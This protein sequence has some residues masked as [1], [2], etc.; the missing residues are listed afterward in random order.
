MN[1]TYK[2]GLFALI[3]FSLLFA[4]KPAHNNQVNANSNTGITIPILQDG[5]PTPEVEDQSVIGST[6]GILMMGII[7]TAIAII[8]LVIRKKRT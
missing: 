2:F 1:N 4:Y 7:I 5:T 3:S 8:P 6:D